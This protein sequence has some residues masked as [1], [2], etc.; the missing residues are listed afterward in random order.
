[1][2][3]GIEQYSAEQCLN[4]LGWD[5]AWISENLDIHLKNKILSTALF[6]FE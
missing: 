6:Q 5:A 1:V 4:R 3:V 2:E